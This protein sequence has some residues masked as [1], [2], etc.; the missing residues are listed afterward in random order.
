MKPYQETNQATIFSA[1]A[2]ACALAVPA[3]AQGPR[4]GAGASPQVPPAPVT[5]TYTNTS[6]TVVQFNYNRDGE[7]EGF[8]LSDNTLVA[9]PPA[10]AS[11]SSAL[12]H[13][14]DTVQVTGLMQGSPTGFRTIQAQGLQDRTSGKTLTIPQPGAAAPYSGSGSIQ[15]LN[16]GPDGSVNGFVLDNGTM[17]LVPPFSATKP[18]SIRVG[19]TISY[20][21]YARNT[22]SGR[23]VV[24]VQTLSINGQTVRL[25]A[26]APVAPV[27]PPVPNAPPP[28]PP[29]GPPVK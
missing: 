10:V 26:A 8:L 16:Y 27:A 25:D 6:G 19:A 2:F 22:S 20:N 9:L 12:V 18:S 15:Q 13:T 17:A 21:G 24:D 11:R 3:V 14:G 1:I 29:T 5:G 7:V 28:V 4:P 23:T